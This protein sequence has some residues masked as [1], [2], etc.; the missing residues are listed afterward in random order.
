[1]PVEL[2]MV[3]EGEGEKQVKER[4]GVMVGGSGKQEA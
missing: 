4:E 1:M 2:Y 3:K